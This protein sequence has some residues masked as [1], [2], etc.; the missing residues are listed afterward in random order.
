MFYILEASAYGRYYS[1]C[2]S[3]VW[4]RW[5]GVGHAKMGEFIIVEV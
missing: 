2:S 4:Y 5:Y 3:R 1:S